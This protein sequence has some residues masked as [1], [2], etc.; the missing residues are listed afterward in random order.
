MNK[1]AEILKDMRYVMG[2]QQ[3]KRFIERHQ[4]ENVYFPNRGS[5]VS[6][7]ERNQA[8]KAD[9]FAGYSKDEL[10]NKYGL[11]MESIYKVIESKD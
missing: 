9:F 4:G 11:S 7:A 8:I 5:Y 1:N 10:I 3:F 2:V 6:I